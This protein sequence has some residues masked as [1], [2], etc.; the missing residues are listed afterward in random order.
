MSDYS[1]ATFHEDDPPS[2]PMSRNSGF[3][4]V[5]P[6]GASFEQTGDEPGS[7]RRRRRRLTPPGFFPFLLGQT[8]VLN[9]VLQ[10]CLVLMG[11]FYYQKSSRRF[12][13]QKLLFR[14]RTCTKRRIIQFVGVM[15]MAFLYYQFACAYVT[16]QHIQD[17]Q[18]S[19]QMT[20]EEHETELCHF[21]YGTSPAHAPA[22]L[23]ISPEAVDEIHAAQDY[24]ATLA[25]HDLGVVRRKSCGAEASPPDN[26]SSSQ[27]LTEMP[28][29]IEKPFWLMT[30]LQ[31]NNSPHVSFRE[32]AENA[33]RDLQTWTSLMSPAQSHLFARLNQLPVSWGC[34][35]DLIAASL[36]ERSDFSLATIIEH[37]GVE[38]ASV[39]EARNISNRN[40][41]MP[42]TI[43][44]TA[45]LHG[46][47]KRPS[48]A[49]TS[50][51]C[52][53]NH[54]SPKQAQSGYTLHGKN[55]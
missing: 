19:A 18:T 33:I 48:K 44:M 17:L 20:I 2:W 22:K 24:V 32:A 1:P 14:L 15:L 34:V 10:L 40:C 35:P 38:R 8:F 55:Y 9:A 45:G 11:S 26:S 21:L 25:R 6:W 54:T 43:R 29:N 13:L 50:G 3:S 49:P 5:G 28:M 47:G 16:Q 37:P 53:G 42:H 41:R 36:I 4:G 23:Y 27:S 51:L 31:T 46:G 12:L 39:E 30:A 52:A 7:L